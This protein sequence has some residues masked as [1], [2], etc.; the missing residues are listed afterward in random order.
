MCWDMEA[1]F[2]VSLKGSR[3]SHDRD[4][5]FHLG[6][7]LVPLAWSSSIGVGAL[8]V[9]AWL[10][11]RQ[12]STTALIIVAAAAV[13][14]RHR[15]RLHRRRSGGAARPPRE[16]DLVQLLGAPLLAV[17]PLRE[18]ALRGL[19]RQLLDHWLRPGARCCRW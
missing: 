5:S 6:A 15:V 11:P 19:C 17:R 9:I 3:M 14:A 4:A 8:L 18:A 10:L 2:F 7:H 12:Y 13:G 1:G 16:R